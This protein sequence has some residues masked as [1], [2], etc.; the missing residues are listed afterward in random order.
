M[1]SRKNQL[2]KL[3][4]IEILSELLEILLQI[5]MMGSTFWNPIPTG[6]KGHMRRNQESV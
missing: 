5:T 1:K 2:F 3:N 6:K 4:L